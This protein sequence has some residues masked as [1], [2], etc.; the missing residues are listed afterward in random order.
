MIILDN[1]IQEKRILTKI[2]HD[3]FFYDKEPHWWNGWW[4]VPIQSMK[5]ELISYIF[6]KNPP[7]NNLSVSGF[8][9]E[10][11]TLQAG[12]KHNLLAPNFDHDGEDK[13]FL[14]AII[15]VN[16]ETDEAEGGYLKLE[17]TKEVIKPKFNR[18]IIFDTGSPYSISKVTK[19]NIHFMKIN[20]WG[21]YITGTEKMPL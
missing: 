9:H 16:P 12:E 3:P 21:K 19:G 5:H 4:N 13:P 17:N 10:V 1:F 8:E 11:F 20:L 14:G 7:V 18:L 6:E 2:Q 15:F